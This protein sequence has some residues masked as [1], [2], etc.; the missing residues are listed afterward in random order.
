MK[1]GILNEF[2]GKEQIY[3]KACELLCDYFLW[4]NH[5]IYKVGVLDES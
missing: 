1:L 2:L 3:V 5:K 4:A